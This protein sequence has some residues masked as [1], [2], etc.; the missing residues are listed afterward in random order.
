MTEDF[1]Q[2]IRRTSVASRESFQ[3]TNGVD[4]LIVNWQNATAPEVRA[5]M[6]LVREILTSRPA[7]SLVLFDVAGMRWDAKLPFEA[8]PW[9]KE[10]TAFTARV[11]ITGVSGLQQTVLTGLRSLTRLQL[12]VFESRSHAT[13]WLTRPRHA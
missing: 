1:D 7:K 12:P 9:I 13:S 2:T 3:R 10:M 11:A 6:D 4:I 5:S 8:V